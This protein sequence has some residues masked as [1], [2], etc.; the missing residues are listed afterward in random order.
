MELGDK[1]IINSEECVI[2]S[3]QWGKVTVQFN[4]EFKCFQI[5]ETSEIVKFTK[6]FTRNV[7]LSKMSL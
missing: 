3:F 6:T 7:W 4:D 1:L 5:F 2:V